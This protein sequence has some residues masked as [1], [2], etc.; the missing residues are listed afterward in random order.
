MILIENNEIWPNTR[1]NGLVGALQYISGGKC[2]YEK[3]KTNFFDT[4]FV[5]N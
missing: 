4:F 5:S 3:K 1:A 2:I